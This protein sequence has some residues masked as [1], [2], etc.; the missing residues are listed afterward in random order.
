VSFANS[1]RFNRGVFGVSNSSPFDG[2]FSL[3]VLP[4]DA[5]IIDGLSNT[6]F[7]SERLCGTFDNSSPNYKRDIKIPVYDNKSIVSDWTFIPECEEA[8]VK[9]WISIAGRYWMYNGAEYGD[10][11]HNGTPNDPRPTCLG[12]IDIGLNPPRSNHRN[13]VNVLFGDGHTESVSNEIN[14]KVWRALGTHAS[15][16]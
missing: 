12:G 2:P 11:S 9:Y 15:G 14:V 8:P 13:S 5:A 4:S 1:Y 6:A 10:Y 7:V 16:D 3:G